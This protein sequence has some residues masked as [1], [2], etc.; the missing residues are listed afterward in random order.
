MLTI[1][2]VDEVY[3]PKAVDSG[4]LCRQCS[5]LL[6]IPVIWTTSSGTNGNNDF[7]EFKF[8]NFHDLYLTNLS[9]SLIRHVPSSKLE[10]GLARYQ[11]ADLSNS[12]VIQPI[13]SPGARINQQESMDEALSASI[14]ASTSTIGARS[15]SYPDS[16]QPIPVF[17]YW[18]F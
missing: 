13:T 5:S 4:D 17:L 11:S 15:D 8:S 14:G 2:V 18:I 10:I 7:F 12:A 9:T 1:P 3:S 6:T 16:E